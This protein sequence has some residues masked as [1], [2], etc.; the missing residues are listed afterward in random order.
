M[1]SKTASDRIVV[2]EDPRVVGADEDVGAGGA[3]FLVG[4]FGLEG[5]SQFALKFD[6]HR[7]AGGL[8][9]GDAGLEAGAAVLPGRD[10]EVV[11]TDEKTRGFA[12]GGR[13]GV[14]DDDGSEYGG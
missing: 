11:G 2:H 8:D 9:A 13:D 7:G 5:L 12:F 3:E 10:Q 1:E 4:E 6:L 14:I